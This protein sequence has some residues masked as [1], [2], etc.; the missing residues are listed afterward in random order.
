[1]VNFGKVVRKAKAFDE[2]LALA[3]VADN[4]LAQNEE[5]NVQAVIQAGRQFIGTD[6]TKLGQLADAFSN[7]TSGLQTIKAF[8]GE[9]GVASLDSGIA[10]FGLIG[11]RSCPCPNCQQM[12][13]ELAES[14]R[15]SSKVFITPTSQSAMTDLVKMARLLSRAEEK[16]EWMME[17]S[18]QIA[19]AAKQA[20]TAAEVAAVAHYLP[21]HPHCHELLSHFLSTVGIKTADE[22]IAILDAAHV[23][24]EGGTKVIDEVVKQ[25]VTRG[26]E[27]GIFELLIEKT[28]CITGSLSGGGI[29]VLG[30]SIP[31]EL[32]EMLGTLGISSV[33]R[34]MRPLGP[35]SSL[36]DLFAAMGR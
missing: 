36:A 23:R 22:A 8:V 28:N 26:I 13:T 12:I 33:S 15:V 4:P 2:L 14:V 1:M 21:I 17:K 5:E 29:S 34:R 32:V 9:H 25:V 20:V 19:E 11:K 27:I 18:A 31:S 6:L 35:S 24:G 30:A 3:P 16:P 7:N 10:L